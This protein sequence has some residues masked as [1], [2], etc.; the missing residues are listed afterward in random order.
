MF[1]FYELD[2]VKCV[3]LVSVAKA[4]TNG[5]VDSH[6][7]FY[8]LLKRNPRVGQIICECASLIDHCYNGK[9]LY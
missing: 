7:S 4:L 8:V 9:S 3:R 2:G 5:V 1:D 6:D